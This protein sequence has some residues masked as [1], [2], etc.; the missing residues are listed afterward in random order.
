MCT[1]ASE[2]SMKMTISYERLAKE[3][4]K[5]EIIEARDASN[6]DNLYLIYLRKNFLREN[7]IIIRWIEKSRE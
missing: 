5:D 2:T 4:S 6:M 7:G 3:K 1:Q